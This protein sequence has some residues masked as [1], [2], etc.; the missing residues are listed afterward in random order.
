[1]KIDILDIN[2]IIYS[3]LSARKID[4]SEEQ[5]SSYICRHVQCEKCYHSCLGESRKCPGHIYDNTEPV[6]TKKDFDFLMQHRKT[7]HG[8]YQSWLSMLVVYVNI[9][10]ELNWWMVLTAFKP[11]ISD[12]NSDG[13]R[14]VMLTYR[15]LIDIWNAMSRSEDEEWKTFCDWIR[16]LPYHE[17]FTEV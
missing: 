4:D 12:A 10:A 9:T 11:V 6:L 14:T 5:R 16:G 17:L 3:L 15:Q 8:K 13:E 1:M 2:G 7:E